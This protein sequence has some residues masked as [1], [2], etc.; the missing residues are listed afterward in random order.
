V[1]EHSN[2]AIIIAGH[3]HT[4]ALIGSRGLPD[5]GICLLP[6]AG[7]DGIYGLHGPSIAGY[8]IRTGYYWTA[9]A[10][11]AP[12]NSVALFYGGNEHH[13]NFLFEQTPGF[14][15][16]PRGLQSL[17]VEADAVIVSESLIRAKFRSLLGAPLQGLLTYLTR[18][19]HSRIT[20]IGTPPPKRDYAG[21]QS[22][23]V[24]N[25]PQVKLTS[26]TKLLKL[27][28][29]LQAILREQAESNDMGFIAVPD[30]ITDEDGFLKPEFSDTDATHGNQAYGQLMLNYLAQRL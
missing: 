20:L 15:F 19:S 3:S 13:A 22:L 4:A 29:V 7:Y 14:D 11:Y 1:A 23:F 5:G 8:P 28:H 6:V 30:A 10:R 2:G 26:S 16:V 18:Q 9:L 27:W 21:F 25:H 17:P 12:G 24:S